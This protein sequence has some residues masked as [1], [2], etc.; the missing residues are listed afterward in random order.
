MIHERENVG[1]V[2]FCN[3]KI[4]IGEADYLSMTRWDIVLLYVLPT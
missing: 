4:K 1:E 2:G 3:K